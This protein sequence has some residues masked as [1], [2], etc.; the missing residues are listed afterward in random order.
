[1]AF[2]SVNGKLVKTTKVT[3]FS[4]A[5]VAEF[6]QHLADGNI[7]QLSNGLYWMRNPNHSSTANILDAIGFT[8]AAILEMIDDFHKLQ[9]H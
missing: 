3:R 2:K 1:M 8:R 6:D 4:P 5:A 7:V 9:L